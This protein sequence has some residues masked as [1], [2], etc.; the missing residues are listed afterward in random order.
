MKICAAENLLLVKIP[1]ALR[2]V[3]NEGREGLGRNSEKERI[4]DLYCT[5]SKTP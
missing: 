4:P 1:L 3:L 5:E 2:L